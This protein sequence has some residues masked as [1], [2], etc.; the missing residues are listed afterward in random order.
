M[1]TYVMLTGTIFGL[2]VVAHIWRMFAESASL[3]TDPWYIV[4]T[5]AAASLCVW[6]LRLLRRPS[7]P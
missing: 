7:P 5:L 4:I 1:R 3:A 2:L 6:A